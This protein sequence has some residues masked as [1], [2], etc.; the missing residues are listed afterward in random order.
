MTGV[1][2]T[3]DLCLRVSAAALAR[4]TFAHP[5]TGEM[6]LALERKATLAKGFVIAQPYGGGMHLL[7]PQAL[8]ELIGD[9]HFDGPRS[10]NEADFRILIRPAD[11][12]RVKQWCLDAFRQGRAGL[13]EMDPARELAEEFWDTLRLHLTPAQYRLRPIEIVVEDTPARTGNV[14]AA[15]LP[16]A[17]IYSVSEARITDP[18]LAQALLAAGALPDETL[19]EQARADT[20]DGRG[21][22][23]GVLT[24]PLDRLIDSYHALTPAQRGEAQR[25]EGHLM[26][27]N[28]AAV[29]PGVEVEK[30]E[31][32]PVDAG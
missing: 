24:L 3:P 23:N 28:V 9:F 29:L 5:A 32:Y 7:Q 27:G 15:G 4:V 12:G 16:T 6:M 17:R 13:L 2:P 21:W 22:A 26:E 11:W 31:R 10:R 19:L 18:A 30:Y 8:R 20:E 25:I 14:H 1:G